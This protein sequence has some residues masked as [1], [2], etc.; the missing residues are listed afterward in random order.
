LNALYC[1]PV[2]PVTPVVPATTYPAGCTSA[3]GFSTTTGLACSGAV[4]YPAG[5]TSAVGFSPTTG[6]SC[7]GTTTTTVG[8]SYGTLSV[9][10]YPVA[11]PVTTLY[12]GNT[13]ETV[14]GQYKA[15]G[16]DITLRKVAVKISASTATVFPWQAFS[17]ISV[18]DGSTML[19]ELPVTSANAIETTFAQ[20]YTFNLSG[21]NW[22]IPSG[23]QKVL[24][25]KVTTVPNAV[26]AATTATWTVSLLTNV[27][28][29]DTAGVTY[30]TVSGDP[31]TISGLILS[32]AQSSTITVTAA[33]DNPLA[34]NVIA[35]VSAP[36][37][38]DVLKFN[39][40]A[41][42]VNATFNSGTIKV[43]VDD[44]IVKEA[45]VT[46]LELWD[47]GTLVAAAAP[48]GWAGNIGTSTW[49]NFTLPISAGTT[50]TL[51]VKAVLAQSTYAN[52]G[53][54]F[55]QITTQGPK[56][57]GI[58]ANSNVVTADGTLV[59]GNKLYPFI[60]AP[61]FAYVSSSATVKGTGTSNLS[62]IGDTSI[63]FSV[64]ANG[65]DIYIPKKSNT[66]V[67]NGM[68]V[69][70]TT[71]T[72]ATTSS[73][74]TWTCNS[75][76]VEDNISGGGATTTLWRITSGNTANCTFSDLLTNTDGTVGYFSVALTGVK[77]YTS[78]T[79]TTD[80]FISQAW[81]FTNIKTADFYLG[82]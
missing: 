82:K 50:K 31:I 80:S 75:P 41:A 36:T 11:S 78:A 7:A 47:G 18:W 35:S 64:T 57:S 60:V 20:I 63:T 81:G 67:I 37:K 23:T 46:S 5:C 29:T 49:S 22:V 14:A 17:A 74:T 56:L 10:T 58:D 24:T 69:T 42:D 1:T 28:S 72:S 39:V 30:S 4:T 59:T 8:P 15:T 52:G 68:S 27:V 43:Q 6:A 3:V 16:S 66:A 34:G 32:A 26:S 33:T 76:A 61:A 53:S 62:D 70:V 44:G 25:V 21:F 55:V 71:P 13:Y 38:V 48:A 45:Y 54:G 65:G 40:K 2:T 77:W 12:G 73:S 19:S 51:T 79:S 9:T